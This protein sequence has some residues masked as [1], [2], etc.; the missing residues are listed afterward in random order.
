M[1]SNPCHCFRESW[2][3]LS[4]R[5]R[6]KL[7][8]PM[9][10]SQSKLQQPAFWRVLKDK[11]K[12]QEKGLE[13]LSLALCGRGEALWLPNPPSLHLLFTY[14]VFPLP[15]TRAQ[16]STPDKSTGQDANGLVPTTTAVTLIS[17]L[18]PCWSTPGAHVGKD[19][20]HSHAP[21]YIMEISTKRKHHHHREG[22]AW[23]TDGQVLLQST[24]LGQSWTSDLL[25][26]PPRPHPLGTKL[27]L[28]TTRE[29]SQ[30]PEQSLSAL[31]V[32]AHKSTVHRGFSTQGC[33]DQFCQ[34]ILF[35]SL[36]CLGQT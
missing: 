1:Q 34:D 17:R 13:S 19:S 33:P 15:V 14:S 22:E 8:T 30:G 12:A 32:Q 36:T 23:L 21:Y 25:H 31:A 29:P 26:L 18:S 11:E 35:F 3:A 10:P 20:F 28:P 5:V 6:G 7:Q 9:A 2:A 16:Q 27:P 24:L 4:H